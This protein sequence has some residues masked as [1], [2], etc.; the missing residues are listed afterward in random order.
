MIANGILA[1]TGSYYYA[2]SVTSSTVYVVIEDFL[3]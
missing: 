2:E 3:P 1:F